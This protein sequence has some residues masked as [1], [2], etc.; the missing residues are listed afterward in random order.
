MAT[1]VNKSTSGHTL[2]MMVAE[3]F[4]NIPVGSGTTITTTK[5]TLS[6]S[7][8]AKLTDPVSGD[9][10]WYRRR[11][12]RERKGERERERGT[13]EAVQ[14]FELIILVSPFGTTTIQIYPPARGMQSLISLSCR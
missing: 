5:T 3:N 13:Q 11:S 2:P 14:L 4:R 7:T 12:G 10:K 8:G 1:I 9:T 6:L